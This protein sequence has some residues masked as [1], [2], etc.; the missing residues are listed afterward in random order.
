VRITIF[1]LIAV[2]LV[3]LIYTGIE[4]YDF[5]S[6]SGFTY[7]TTEVIPFPV[8]KEGGR[9]ISY[10]SYL[11][12]LRRNIHYYETQ[13]QADFSSST[14]KT[15]LNSLKQQAMGQVIQDAYVKQL[16]KKYN[17]TVS[18]AQLN[19]EISLVK[20]QNRLGNSNQVLDSVLREYWGWTEGDFRQE[21]RSQLLQQQVVAK[22]DTAT[23]SKAMNVYSQ[24]IHGGD[25]ASL[26]S[27]NSDDS[28]TRANGGQ[29]PNPISTQSNNV[30]PQIVA[31]LF[32]LKAGQYSPV[33]NTGY[34]L[35][36]VKVISVNGNSVQAAHIQFN[37]K[38][39]T[40]FT[41][42]LK[43]ANPPSLYIKVQ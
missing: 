36:I 26:A 39:I 41:D 1:L 20:Q 19:K 14:G 40:I 32:K 29:Y 33:I 8:A 6:T 9:W 2:V 31:E 28:S 15:Q 12:E 25:F 3:F 27:I 11:F 16:A 42:P 23:N 21:L 24:L 13:Q 18:N 10:Y 37:F 30:S 17:I 38:P 34:S 22:L 5:Q 35:E 7:T 43:K 4:L